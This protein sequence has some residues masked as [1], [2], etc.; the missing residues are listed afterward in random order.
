MRL[1]LLSFRSFTQRK[2]RT[3]L[4][5]LGIALGVTIILSVGNMIMDYTTALREMSTFFQGNVVVTPRNSLFIQ[6]LPIGGLL[7]EEIVEDVKGVDGVEEAVPMLAVINLQ[8]G[9]GGGGME[10]SPLVPLNISFGI[11]DERWEVLVGSTPLRGRWPEP[12]SGEDEVVIGSFLAGGNN[13][14]VGSEIKIG[15]HTLRVV[16]V[17]ETS[18]D[19]LTRLIIMSLDV[20]QRVYGYRRLINMIVVELEEGISEEELVSSIESQVKGVRVLTTEARGELTEPLF[21][22][23]ELW[24]L[25][26]RTALFLM[27]MVLVATVT[28]INISERRRELATLDAIG[29]QKGFILRM[30]TTEGVLLGLLGGLVGTI[31]GSIV[32]VLLVSYYAS[33]PIAMIFR[34]LLGIIKLRITIEVFVSTVIVSVAA[35]ALPALFFLRT[36]IIEAL[37]SEH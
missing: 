28:T 23:L 21:R 36:N 34:N 32:S 12:D 15:T 11:A 3:I 37:R 10:L 19:F 16:G 25:G 35:S 33:V 18:S 1:T 9:G 13:L 20:T 22:D 14:T 29:A 27:C 17:L 2:A 6:T 31:L 5:L 7:S 26:L 4:C 24:D 30:V 8:L